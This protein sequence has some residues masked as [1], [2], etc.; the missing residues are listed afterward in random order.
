MGDQVKLLYRRRVAGKLAAVL[1][2]ISLVAACGSDNNNSS[3]SST[4]A[5]ESSTSTVAVDEPEEVE[6]VTIGGRLIVGLE[7]ETN[8]W[9]PALG[10]LNTF[11][12]RT[13]FDPIAIR[14]GDGEIYPYLAEDIQANEDLSEWTVTLREG[15]KFHDGTD[16][17]ANAI[18]AN[19]DNYLAA[20]GAR[21][22]GDA[23]QVKELRV[24]DEL[25]YTYVL[26]E[27]NAAFVDLLTGRMGYPFSNE[28]CEEWGESCGD[29]P[30]GTGPFVFESWSRDAELKVVK[31]EDYWRVDEN[32][33]QL[34]YL[35]EVIFRPIPDEDTRF[36][37]VRSGDIQVGVTLRQ[38]VVRQAMAAEESGEIN[39]LVT[40]GNNG[41]AAIMNTMRPPVDDLRVRQALAYAIDQASLV[42]VLGGEGITPNQTQFFSPDSPWFSQAVADVFPDNDPDKAR[43][44]L[45]DYM[46]DPE[47]SDGK[48]AGEPVTIDF[49]CPPDPTLI[50]LSQG[51]QAFWGD[52]GIV[53]NV[54]QVDQAIHIT[55]AVGS[56]DQN[57][58]FLGNYMV[59]CWRLGD[60][61][62]PYTTLRGQY[63]NPATEP[64]NV[65]NYFTPTLHENMEKLGTSS[66]FA[67]RYEAVE[68]MMMEFAEEVPQLWLGGTANAMFSTK[69]VHNL[70][71]WT[72]PGNIRGAGMVAAYTFL[73]ETWLEK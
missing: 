67:S 60:E 25:T 69:K 3:G 68:A 73:T 19:F 72:I 8:N 57:P 12:A 27:G 45:D 56:A 24:D 15:V 18:K 11:V 47:R 64:A 48:A 42:A 36:Q 1:A 40:I 61:A 31:N 53:T 50:Q 20:D 6:E 35:D 41:G 46:N 70:D 4:T 7:A 44:L 2:A 5:P 34:P 13:F 9:S 52:V 33:I 63:G 22:A 71:G 37:A 16:L 26:E 62:D 59:N 14:G 49:A 51:F 32:G 58:P 23:S 28:A 54:S 55:N 30:V 10:S 39:N 17:D 38:T 43:E 65:T 29:H 21:S 66:D